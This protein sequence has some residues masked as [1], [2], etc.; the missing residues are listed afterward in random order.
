MRWSCD[1]VTVQGIAVLAWAV[2]VPGPAVFFTQLAHA[3]GTDG[4][5]TSAYRAGREMRAAACV[6]ERLA[7][8]MRITCR[9]RAVTHLVDKVFLARRTEAVWVMPDVLATLVFRCVRAVALHRLRRPST[10]AALPHPVPEKGSPCVS[11]TLRVVGGPFPVSGGKIV[12]PPV[13]SRGRSLTG[14]TRENGLPHFALLVQTRGR[15]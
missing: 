1:D 2:A 13:H 15:L 5:D 3:T 10:K 8:P 7:N 14:G 6:V 9:A 4:K 11:P 12:N